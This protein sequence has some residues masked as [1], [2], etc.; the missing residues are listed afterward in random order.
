MKKLFH[1]SLLLMATAFLAI[2]CE[3]HPGNPGDFSIQC[4]IDIDPVMTSV[5]GHQIT[6]TPVRTIDSTFRYFYIE[7]D[8]LKDDKGTPII[9]EDGKLIVKE[10]TIYYNSKRTAHFTE[11]ALE[12]LPW[13]KDTFTISFRSNAQWN[14]N[15]PI[16]QTRTSQTWYYNYNSTTTGGGDGVLCFR[17]KNN[18]TG[19]LREVEAVQDI[20]SR[21]SS[22]MVRFH[23]NQ[24][25]KP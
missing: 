19:K 20:Y 13:E 15:V 4:T 22:V 1:L 7:E 5:K 21:D 6:L 23:F 2:A 12:L 16:T 11:Y 18:T 10:D 25:P 8:T 14:A 24:N 3:D 17:T 9:G